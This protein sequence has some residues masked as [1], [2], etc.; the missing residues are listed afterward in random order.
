MIMIICYFCQCMGNS[1]GN[2]VSL[3]SIPW[4]SLSGQKNTMFLISLHEFKSCSLLCFFLS[5]Y[6]LSIILHFL[7]ICLTRDCYLIML[8]LLHGG[9]C[10]CDNL[11]FRGP[12]LVSV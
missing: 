6:D 10:L 11:V 7:V 4:F 12:N 1:N 8:G 9:D 2:V 5:V 3:G